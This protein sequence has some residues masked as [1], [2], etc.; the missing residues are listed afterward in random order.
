MGAMAVVVVAAAGIRHS[1][2]G[3]AHTGRCELR[4]G[5]KSNTARLLFVS[6]SIFLLELL[7]LLY[8]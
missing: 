3:L 8:L 6:E 7:L 1:S 2:Y 4:D 5:L